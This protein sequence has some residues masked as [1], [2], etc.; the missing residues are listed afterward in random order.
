MNSGMDAA[1]VLNVS[2]A[3]AFL[4]RDQLAS[5]DTAILRIAIQSLKLILTFRVDYCKGI[6]C[7]LFAPRQATGHPTSAHVIIQQC[8][9]R[10]FRAS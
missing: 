4:S 1:V 5:Q 7:S 9:G 2:I 10:E 3:D 6:G 8:P